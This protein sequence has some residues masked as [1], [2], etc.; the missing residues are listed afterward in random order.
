MISFWEA[1]QRSVP[2]AGSA[3]S[4]PEKRSVFEACS[5][6]EELRVVK[7]EEEQV[8]IRSCGSDQD[9]AD[10]PVPGGGSTL[11]GRPVA[12]TPVKRPRGCTND[13]GRF[14]AK[15]SRDAQSD[16]GVRRGCD[17]KT[18]L[19]LNPFLTIDTGS[20]AH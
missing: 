19:L 3:K 9:E 4:W 2:S 12:S 11:I 15:R 10:V 14:P 13:S 18:D 1:W 16:V 8:Q 5:P 20:S 17:E 7:E 6:K